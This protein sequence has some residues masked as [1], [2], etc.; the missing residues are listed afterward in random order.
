MYMVMMAAML[1]V[2]VFCLIIGG[3]KES[4]K[5]WRQRYC[6]HSEY[7]LEPV[8]FGPP[9]SRNLETQCTGCGSNM[10]YGEVS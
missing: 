5:S 4:D 3:L 7:G 8:A 2:G 6:Q 9:W 10:V 1:A